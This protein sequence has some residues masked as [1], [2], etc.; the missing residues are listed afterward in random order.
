M[1]APRSYDDSGIGLGD[2]MRG[3]RATLGKS[4]LDVQR[5]LKIKAQIIA[6]IENADASAFDTPGFIAGYLRSYARY[7]GMDPDRAFE[8]FCAESGFR[9]GHGMSAAASRRPTPSAPVT[10]AAD[11]DIFA[12]GAM[13]YAPPPEALLRRIEPGAIGS[14]AVLVALVGAVGW[15]GWQLLQQMQRVTIEAPEEGAVLM[16]EIDPLAP[17]GEGP[18]VAE[19][20]APEPDALDRLYRPRAL[21]V[22]VLVARDGPIG[23]LEPEMPSQPAEEPVETA[24]LDPRGDQIAAPRPTPARPAGASDGAVREALAGDGEEPAPQ[25]VADAGEA[26]VLVAVR[27]SWVRVR[28]PDGTVVLEKIMEAGETYAVP[29]TEVPATLRTGNAGSI[30]FRVGDRAFGPAGD[31]PTIVSG[32]EL[33]PGAVSGGFTVAD[34]EGDPELARLVRVAEAPPLD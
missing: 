21:D 4:L 29:R 13:P 7:L 26:V 2:L 6:S 20:A 27:P 5:D 24:A 30:Y 18:E 33:S 12:A 19:P 23:A 9:P 25:V 22:P 14:L 8:A 31:G 1:S 17:A 34:L 28:A 11:R 3:E 16:S 10:L 15:G 32:V